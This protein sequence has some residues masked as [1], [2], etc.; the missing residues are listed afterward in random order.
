[1]DALHPVK[2][3]HGKFRGWRAIHLDNGII[4]LAI[5]P[6][7]GGRVMALDLDRYEF[8]YVDPTLAG[9]LFT[10]SE[11]I[12]DGTP[13]AWKNYG[14]DKT[15]PAPQGW[16]NDEQWHGP[17]DPV[18]DGGRYSLAVLQNKEDL[19]CIELTSA[20]EPLTGVQITR[21]ITVQ[22][23][24]SRVKLELSFTNTSGRPRRWSIWDV[25]Q[26]RAGRL[27]ENGQS[28]P[29][30]ECVISAPLNPRSRFPKGYQVMFA[31]PDNPQWTTDPQRQLLIARYLYEIGKIGWDSPGGWIAFHN[32]AEA[33]SFIVNFTYFPDAEYPDQGA[34]LECWTVG[35][36]KI[37]GINYDYENSGIYLMETEVLSPL[38]TFHPG[39][40]R[41]FSVEWGACRTPGMVIEA[42][43]AGAI[44][45]PLT[46]A[47]A[48]GGLRLTG[49]F[50]V[51]D[52]GVL[53]VAWLDEGRQVLQTLSLELV[54][55]SR[56]LLFDQILAP[57]TGA[58]SVRIQVIADTDRS[59]RFLAEAAL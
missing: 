56:P 50:G 40:Q 58:T 10:P 33:A 9:K 54:T 28:A 57:P 23:G 46:A 47:P 3:E 15:W 1:M 53:E 7:I 45:R 19:V 42:S 12:G 13:N 38:F 37:P 59:T 20:P 48:P 44:S 51:Y 18:L 17:P 5:T 26:L 31:N 2:F 6:D 25:T 43:P 21:R 11:H 22:R 39:E 14:G 36:G 30:T 52:Q 16:D 32:G 8:F 35:R 24:N 49:G 41:N 29:E 27:L 4:H 34:S 55:P